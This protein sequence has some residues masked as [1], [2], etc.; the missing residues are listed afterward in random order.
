MTSTSVKFP[1]VSRGKGVRDRD[2]DDA[3]TSAFDQRLVEVLMMSCATV[4]CYRCY[5]VLDTRNLAFCEAA[6]NGKIDI[7][8]ISTVWCYNKR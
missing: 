6:G 2:I 8:S 3:T 1:S 5:R 7:G 4:S